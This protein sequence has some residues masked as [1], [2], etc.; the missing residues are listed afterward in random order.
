MPKYVTKITAINPKDGN[1]Y[2]W[3]GPYI[4]ADSF[5]EAQV[6]CE[7]NGLGYCEVIGEYISEIDE[8][9]APFASR[10]LD[11]SILN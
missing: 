8:S 6:Y 3:L 11:D 9:L 2:T 4:D 5:Y 7:N 10:L 1:L